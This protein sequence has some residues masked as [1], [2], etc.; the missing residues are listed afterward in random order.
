MVCCM[1][2]RWDF[3]GYCVAIHSRAAAMIQFPERKP[4]G[5]TQESLSDFEAIR[6]EFF[7]RPNH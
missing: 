7:L 1:V 5:L 3:G 6:P 2:R 4:R